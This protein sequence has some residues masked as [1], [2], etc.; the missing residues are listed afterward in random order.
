MR[1]V[2]PST[3]G[4]AE[5]RSPRAG[6]TLSEPPAAD[7]GQTKGTQGLG[8]P[9]DLAG[10]NERNRDWL[11]AVRE[12]PLGREK[13]KGCG[14]WAETSKVGDMGMGRQELDVIG[15]QGIRGIRNKAKD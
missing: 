10:R 8:E 4:A 7:G 3:P 5:P 11:G 13:S 12:S 6:S 14:Q 2:G 9:E 1:Y 15:T